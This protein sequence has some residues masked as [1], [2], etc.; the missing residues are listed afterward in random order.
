MLQSVSPAS[1]LYSQLLEL[2]EVLVDA[3][4]VGTDV[5]KAVLD[6]YPADR[7]F[8][9]DL[10]PEFLELGHKLYDDKDTCNVTFFPD[11]VFCVDDVPPSTQTQNSPVLSAEAETVTKLNDL[12]GRVTHLFTS[13][14]FHLFDEV[15]QADMAY[16]LALLMSWKPGSIMFGRHLA[17]TE[18]GLF[19]SKWARYPLFIARTTSAQVRSLRLDW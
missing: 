10:L 15:L 9:C 11:A 4:L 8:G 14:V 13:S 19:Q 16:R 2:S 18:K 12:R 3:F 1:A 7:V 5:R 6:G 17:N